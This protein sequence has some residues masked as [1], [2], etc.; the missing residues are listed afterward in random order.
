VSRSGEESE[1]AP[2]V[3][4][5]DDDGIT[6]EYVAGLLRGSGLVVEAV[7]SGSAAVE[8]VRRGGVDV[9]LLDVMMPGLSGIEA[10]RLVKSIF[11]NDFLPVILLTARSDPD[12]RVEGL[13]IGA[14]DYVSKPF[15]ERELLARVQGMLRIKRLHDDVQSAKDRLEK[16]A[17]RDELTGLYNYRYLHTRLG[18][19]FKRAERYRDPL[20]CVVVDVDDFKGVNDRYG[21]QAGDAVLSQ[22]ASRLLETVREIDV[23]ARYGGDEFLMILPSTHFTGALTVADRCWRRVSKSPYQYDGVSFRVTV[24]VGVALYPSRDVTS[25]DELL[26]A[27][28]KALYQSKEDGRDGICV[29]QHQ[30]YIYRPDP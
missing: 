24:S 13:R 12:S 6:R 1:R 20:A 7:E 4:V 27:A 3:V 17:V 15:D 28:D 11:A 5:A 30:G 2:L 26:K 23:V 9:L 18:E 14:D 21:H 29:F 10:C 16:L 22:L 8:R 25:K 19:E